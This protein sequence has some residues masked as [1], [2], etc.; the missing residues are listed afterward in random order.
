MRSQDGLSFITKDASALSTTQYLLKHFGRFG[1]PLQLRSDNGAHFIAEVIKVFL[2]HIGT[3][4]CL[5][6]AYSKEENANSWAYEQ[7]SQ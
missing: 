2:S 5:K 7:T 1:A 4:H 3:Q 6:L